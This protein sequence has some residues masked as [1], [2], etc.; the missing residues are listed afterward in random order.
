MK[1]FNHLT[2]KELKELRTKMMFEKERILKSHNISEE[3]FVIAK[4]D[5]SDE[6]DLANSDYEN[7]HMLRMRNREIFYAKKLESALKKFDNGEYGQCEDCGSEIK[8]QRLIARPTAEL[9][10]SCKEE[11]E[12]E[13]LRSLQGRKSKSYSEVV[14]FSVK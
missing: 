11:S 1:R 12:T 10:I 4:D 3:K 9:C 7:S 5:Q 6:V 13:E 2:I 14:D 8:F